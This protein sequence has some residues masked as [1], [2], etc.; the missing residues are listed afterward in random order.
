MD[1]T[2][3]HEPQD[4]TT[5]QDAAVPTPTGAEQPSAE[6]D[7]GATPDE[8]LTLDE[9]I[10]RATAEDDSAM[11]PPLDASEPVAAGAR[12][13]Y[14]KIGLVALAGAATVAAGFGIGS[15]IADGGHDH[16]HRGDADGRSFEQRD[17]EHDR[18]GD[19]DGSGVPRGM[20]PPQGGFQG[21]QGTMPSGGMQGRGSTSSHGS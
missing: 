11:P 9:R 13:D 7:L 10:A 16:G 6:A 18:D 20:T 3:P 4:P 17:G 21:G 15:A 5:E 12:R 2:T 8:P 14:K 1:E 19:A